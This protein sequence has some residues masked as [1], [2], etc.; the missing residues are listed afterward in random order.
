MTEPDPDPT[1]IVTAD[2]LA[3]YARGDEYRPRSGINLAALISGGFVTIDEPAML[4]DHKPN[5]EEATD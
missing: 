2:N 1:F 3:G 4:S 5:K